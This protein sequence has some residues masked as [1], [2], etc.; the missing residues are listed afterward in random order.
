MV[1]QRRIGDLTKKTFFVLRPS[2][3]TLSPRTTSVGTQ[4]RLCPCPHQTRDT[5][6]LIGTPTGGNGVDRTTGLVT[7]AAEVDRGGKDGERRV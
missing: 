5:D 2:R 4:V 1:C 3:D 7:P 6:V